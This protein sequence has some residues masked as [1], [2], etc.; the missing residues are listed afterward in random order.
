M[1]L[2]VVE[3]DS[4]IVQVEFA[5]IALVINVCVVRVS[6]DGEGGK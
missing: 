6:G 3:M 1:K 4:L 2:V 5:Q